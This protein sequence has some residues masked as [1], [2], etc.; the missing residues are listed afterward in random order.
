MGKK[1]GF[2]LAGLATLQGFVD[3]NSDS[4]VGIRDGAGNTSC[5][6]CFHH[7]TTAGFLAIADADH[8]DL[9][10]NAAIGS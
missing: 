7:H 5:S 1:N 10:F 3:N 2:C 9:K 8:V 6:P 4:V